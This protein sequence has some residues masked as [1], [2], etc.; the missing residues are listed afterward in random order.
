MHDHSNRTTECSQRSKGHSHLCLHML[1]ASTAPLQPMHLPQGLPRLILLMSGTQSRILLVMC[2]FTLS[3]QAPHLHS[4]KSSKHIGIRTLLILRMTGD[5]LFSIPL[6]LHRNPHRARRQLVL[7]GV[8]PSHLLPLSVLEGLR[9]ANRCLRAVLCRHPRS[10]SGSA[11]F[12]RFDN[13]TP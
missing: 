7:L 12:K 9:L 4:W 5:A 10:L 6:S 8:T 11:L 1:Y 2:P 13:N 3:P